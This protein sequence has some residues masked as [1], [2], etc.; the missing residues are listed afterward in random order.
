MSSTDTIFSI[1]LCDD[2]CGG[3]GD[4][5]T[6]VHHNIRVRIFYPTG[7]AV[8]PPSPAPA[9]TTL[10][11]WACACWPQKKQPSTPKWLPTPTGAYAEAYG[12]FMSLPKWLFRLFAT[13]FSKIDS[14]VPADL[15]PW[16]TRASALVPES[17][18]N[19]SRILKASLADSKNTGKTA[20]ME[21]VND[22]GTQSIALPESGWPLV[23][24]SHG[25]GGS[26]GTYGVVCAEVL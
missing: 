14:P 7:E 3:D 2:S 4:G 17:T 16:P 21:V 15:P 8:A 24:F 20:S 9:P 26:I 23:L 25:L 18:D 5:P 13:K 11:S 19:G 6:G 1:T 10:R 12:G 22:S